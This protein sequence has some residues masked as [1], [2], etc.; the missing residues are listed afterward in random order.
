M[1]FARCA[2]VQVVSGRSTVVAGVPNRL[3]CV[4]LDTDEQ[5]E[6]PLGSDP[7][8]VAVGDQVM[9]AGTKNGTLWLRRRD[10]PAGVEL[11]T[12]EVSSVAVV[13]T[14]LGE[15]VVATGLHAGSWAVAAVDAGT[16]RP[17]WREVPSWDPMRSGNDWRLMLDRR[18]A[19]T[20]KA[21]EGERLTVLPWHDEDMPAVVLHRR[22]TPTVSHVGILRLSGLPTWRLGGKPYWGPSFAAESSVR[23]MDFASA[24]TGPLALWTTDALVVAA[25]FP[26]IVNDPPG[27]GLMRLA[28]RLYPKQELLLVA[29]GTALLSGAS[30]ATIGSLIAVMFLLWVAAIFLRPEEHRPGVAPRPET[31]WQAIE[32][33]AE[34][35]TVAFEAPSTVVAATPQGLITV[36]LNE[37]DKA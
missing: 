4:H 7:T 11:F 10:E 33:D 8:V 14:H 5:E 36:E 12:G 2:V 22:Y 32:L 3:V 27:S 25:D 23:L 18:P 1:K 31:R 29:V 26:L 6:F 34:V 15:V 30:D 21:L 20:P 24:S 19:V 28:K 35:S 13:P 9:A 16:G 37:I 17:L